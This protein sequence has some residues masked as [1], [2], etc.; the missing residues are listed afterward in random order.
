MRIGIV[1]G[2]GNISTGVVRLLLEQGHDVTCVTRGRAP[3]PEGARNLVGDREDLDW[4]I[5]TMQAEKFDAA[6][7]FIAFHPE[8]GE[9]S[10]EAFR[11]VGHFIHVSTVMT[12][13]ESPRWLPVTE[14][15]PDDADFPYAKNKATIDRRYEAAHLT[16]GFPVTIIRPFTTYGRARVVRQLGIDTRWFDRIRNGR[17]ILKVGEGNAIHHLLHVDDAAP[18]FAGVLGRERCIGQTY[19]LVNPVHT[20]WSEVH[21][22]AMEVIGTEVEQVPIAA[23][24][25]FTAD[26]QR[27]MLVP[28]N[29]SRNLLFS[30]AKLQRDVPEFSPK[31]SLRDGLADAYEYLARNDLIEHVPAGDWEDQLIGIQQDAARRA[32]SVVFA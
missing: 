19:N 32:S 28:G 30:A 27:F 22:T 7:D 25:L 18:A 6:I 21:A 11:D 17:P 2:S 24:I 14:D 4:F 20:T 23:D 13:G 8:Q 15:H 10:L 16:D 1:G 12:Y 3:V 5:P 31:V 29:F 9:A 26:P